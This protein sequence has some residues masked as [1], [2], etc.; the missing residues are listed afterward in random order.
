VANSETKPAPNRTAATAPLDRPACDEWGFYDPAQAGFEAVLR[1]L[2]KRA[3][4]AARINVPQVA[5][6]T[7]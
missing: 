6:S 4:D 5:E 3:E 7:T 2:E 1:K